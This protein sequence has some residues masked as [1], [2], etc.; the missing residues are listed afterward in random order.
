MREQVEHCARMATPF[1][2][3]ALRTRA[4]RLTSL[5]YL[6][7]TAKE[8]APRT[9]LAVEAC[10]QVAC[11][12]A[13]ARFR[14][15]LPLELEG[16]P[17]RRR[18]WLQ[19]AAI[20]SGSALTYGAIAARLGS[21]ARAVGAA[22]GDNPVPLVVPCHRVLA[23]GGIGGFMHASDGFALDVKRWLLAHEGL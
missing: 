21:A 11:Y 20:P 3:V 12:V 5:E 9:S 1:A 14:F 23:A 10:R 15:D 16:T 2:V 22:C 17:F 19:I 8:L 4:D 6:P 7:L 18:V 13:D